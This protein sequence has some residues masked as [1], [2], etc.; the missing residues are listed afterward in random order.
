MSKTCD[1]SVMKLKWWNHCYSSKPFCVSNL[2]FSCWMSTSYYLQRSIRFVSSDMMKIISV[3]LCYF[4]LGI[5]SPWGVLQRVLWGR[6][7]P[8]T[9]V[10]GSDRRAGAAEKESA[11]VRRPHKVRAG[12][13]TGSVH[14]PED[15]APVSGDRKQGTAEK[16]N[17][18]N[19]Y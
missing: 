14:R 3:H 19:K 15:T 16:V 2:L 12:D 13:P 4:W 18:I 1:F 7:Q 10:R 6:E 5:G 17:R 8:E 9:G 11:A